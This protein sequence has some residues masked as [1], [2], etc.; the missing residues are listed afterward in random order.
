[1]RAEPLH[2]FALLAMLEGAWWNGYGG[3]GRRWCG[4]APLRLGGKF[5][6]S[7]RIPIWAGKGHDA[8]QAADGSAPATAAAAKTCTVHPTAP[9]TLHLYSSPRIGSPR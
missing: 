3:Y 8:A 4:R 5:A 7:G 1:M 2:A 6:G 9:R